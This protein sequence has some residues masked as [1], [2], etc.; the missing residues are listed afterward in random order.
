MEKLA[1][2]ELTGLAV[3]GE[4]LILN[5]E[6]KALFNRTVENHSIHNIK[7]AR[8]AA[9]YGY[10][11]KKTFYPYFLLFYLNAFR[12]FAT[13][14]IKINMEEF[15][16]W[17]Y[18]IVIIIAGISSLIGSVNKRNRQAAEKKQAREITTEEWVDWEDREMPQPVIPERQATVSRRHAVAA[19]GLQAQHL[20]RKMQDNDY[21]IFRKETERSAPFAPYTEDNSATFTAEDLPDGTDEWRKAFIYNEIFKRKY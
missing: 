8:Q 13:K 20:S 11:D 3:M 1:D 9:D 4:S 16:D 2:I 12:I 18:L 17:L 14:K 19:P 21:S 5:V 15:G 6:N 7:N 10:C